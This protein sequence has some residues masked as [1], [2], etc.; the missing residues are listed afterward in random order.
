MA[1]KA[2]SPKDVMGRKN[3]EIPWEGEW[4]ESFGNIQYNEL[5]FISGASA[6]GKSSFVMQLA[7]ELTKYG[8]VLYGSYEEGVGDSFKK[9]IQRE[10]MTEKQGRFR[11]ITEDSFEDLME[12]L[13]KPKGPKFVIIDS[14]QESGLTYEQA[15]ALREKFPRKGWIYISQEYKGAPMGK[16]A[17]RLKYKAGVKIRVVGYKAYCQGRFTGDESDAFTIWEDGVIK[18]TNNV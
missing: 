1:K 12:R 3:Q 16:A 10:R 7:R 9:R 13:S 18:S 4:R 2:Y 17:A 5:W 14:F 11:I 6:S 8:R 15:V